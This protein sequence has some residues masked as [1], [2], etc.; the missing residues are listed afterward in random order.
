MPKSEALEIKLLGQRIALKATQTDPVR[1]REVVE[2]VSAKLRKAEKRAPKGLV[3]PH[4]VALLALLE[5][6][7]EYLEAR[8]KTSVFKEE[9]ERRSSRLLSI[10]ESELGG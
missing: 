10:I 9:I 4:Q 6:A 5:L 3:S 1:T 7:D 2:F 8:E